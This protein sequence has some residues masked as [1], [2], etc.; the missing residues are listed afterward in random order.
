MVCMA[1]ISSLTRMVPDMG[2]KAEP[3]RPYDDGSDQ[4]T[5]SRSTPRPEG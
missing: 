3:L 4:S 1:S 2:V 5:I